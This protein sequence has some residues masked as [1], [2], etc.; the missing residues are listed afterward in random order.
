[1]EWHN[2]DVANL[3]LIDQQL[4]GHPLTSAEYEILRRVIYTTGD[5]DYLNLL[6]YS[7]Q[8]LQ[9][10]V[11]ALAAH[12]PIV[13]DVPMVQVGIL[14]QT[15]V[16]FANPIY[17][18]LE[19]FTRPQQE[20][21]RAAFGVETLAR[22]HP[23]AIFIIGGSQATI[24]PLLSLVESEDIKPALIVDT[25]PNFIPQGLERLQQSWVPHIFI[26]GTKGGVAVATAIVNGLIEL[27][28]AAYGQEAGH[29]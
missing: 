23:T 26:K 16:T 13:V 28:W 18:G 15:Q 7:E 1:M 2:S 21:S 20:K 3:H 10:A 29:G 17:C 9:S 11:A 5:F 6:V 25:S 27:A 4:T 8:A 19:T 14:P 12:T 24:L 22:R